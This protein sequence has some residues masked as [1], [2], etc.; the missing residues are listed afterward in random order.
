MLCIVSDAEGLSENVID[1]RTGFVVPKR[2][3][4]LLCNK[5]IQ[6][7]GYTSKEKNLM[8]K[9][10]ILRIKSLFSLNVQNQKFINFYEENK[11]L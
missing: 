1:S 4:V 7:V 6:V 8:V 11:M 10:S 2:N 5:I 9:E 3:P